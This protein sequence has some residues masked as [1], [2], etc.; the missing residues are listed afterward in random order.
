MSSFL[1][2]FEVAPRGGLASLSK[3][4][5]DLTWDVRPLG[6]RW[7]LRGSGPRSAIADFRNRAK[8]DRSFV[9][10]AGESETEIVLAYSP[11]AGET[12][13]LRNIAEQGG[14]I[15]PPMLVKDGTL[16]IRYVTSRAAEVRGGN[17]SLLRGRLVSRRR[18]TVQ[19]LHD[20]LEQ[21]FAGA[22]TLTGRQAEVLLEAVR[23]GYYEVPRRSTV[24]D[25]ARR[26]SLG[27][28]T[29]EEHLRIA[30]SA[31][32]RSAAPL[33]ASSQDERAAATE[34]VEHFVRYSSE[35]SLNVALALRGGQVTEV[36][37]R[38][39]APAA[40]V[41]RDHPYLDRILAHI[42]T[43]RTNLDSIP[44]QLDLRKFEK[45]VLEEI[46]R[47]PPGE[48]RTYAEIARRIGHPSAVR[49]V[50]NACAHNPV[51]V[52]IPCHRVIP[53][54]GGIGQYSGEGGPETKRRLLRQ[55]GAI[56]EG[57]EKALRRGS[58][59]P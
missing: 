56:P 28:S 46:R 42:R 15:L 12:T 34:P 58:T 55:E 40:G 45:K 33:A 24:M 29:A 11:K 53:S 1:T 26:L 54:R 52:V 47:I 10:A 21:Q 2:E 51:I 14:F 13:L 57:Q 37:F 7:F 36:R 5:P 16:R 6:F 8:H 22:P 41:D 44:V 25:I 20:E 4:H 50:G 9:W 38:R 19:R 17:G 30:E 23:S 18:M 27:R 43:G 49:A 48:T 39:S 31:I 35:L 59:R 3:R 32:V